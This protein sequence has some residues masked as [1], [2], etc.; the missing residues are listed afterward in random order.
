[1]P[2]KPGKGVAYL[3]HAAKLIGGIADSP[4]FQLQQMRQ[5]FLIQFA[6]AFLDV[7]GENKI[8]ER[9]KLVIVMREYLRPPGIDALL[10]RDGRQGKGYVG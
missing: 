4:V 8:Q 2:L 1:M 9:L 5:F 10:P 7:L 3:C 6:V